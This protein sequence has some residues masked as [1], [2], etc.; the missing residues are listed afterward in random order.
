MCSAINKPGIV[1]PDPS[2]PRHWALSELYVLCPSPELELKGENLGVPPFAVP[3]SYHDVAM[4]R[5]LTPPAP[6]GAGGTQQQ[7]H[8]EITTIRTKSIKNTLPGQFTPVAPGVEKNDGDGPWT[9]MCPRSRQWSRDSSTT[10]K[11]DCLTGG[12]VYNKQRHIKHNVFSNHGRSKGETSDESTGTNNY[13]NYSQTLQ[14]A[15]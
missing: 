15:E 13:E 10:S 4:V 9:V 1:S 11:N 7:T 6:M 14:E 2:T 8:S 3:W 12:T 5:M